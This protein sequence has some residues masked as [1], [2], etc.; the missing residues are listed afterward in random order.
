MKNSNKNREKLAKEWFSRA[1]DD[2]LSIEDIGIIKMNILKEKS[3]RR[4]RTV[5]CE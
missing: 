5:M 4:P 3:K 1:H 2:E